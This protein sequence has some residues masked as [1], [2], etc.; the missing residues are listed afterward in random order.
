MKYCK[1][2]S[3]WHTPPPPI[4]APPSYLPFLSA[5]IRFSYNNDIAFTLMK[6]LTLETMKLCTRH[7]RWGN[8]YIQDG[9][10]SRTPNYWQMH[11]DQNKVSF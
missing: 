8:L 11:R 3:P 7:T 10:V 5:R 9:P 1:H 4:S 2:Q 6:M